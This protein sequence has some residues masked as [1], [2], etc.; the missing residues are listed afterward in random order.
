M[1]LRSRILI[2][3]KAEQG[4]MIVNIESWR[5]ESINLET[6]FWRQNKPTLLCWT[7]YEDKV[8]NFENSSKKV[9][10][11]GISLGFYLGRVL[12]WES[13]SVPLIDWIPLFLS[14]TIDELL[15]CCIVKIL[16]RSTQFLDTMTCDIQSQSDIKWRLPGKKNMF[17]FLTWLSYWTTVFRV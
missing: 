5:K 3:S 11:F 10:L 7:L 15:D 6:G 16:K 1:S 17:C 13:E 12:F 4:S 8:F 14:L 2:F 9:D